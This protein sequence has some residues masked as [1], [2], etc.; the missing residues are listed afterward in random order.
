MTVTSEF[1]TNGKYKIDLE[2]S[3][4]DQLIINY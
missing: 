4:E 2:E 3:T 1:I